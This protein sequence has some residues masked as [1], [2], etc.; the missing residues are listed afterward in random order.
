[1][2]VE[3][4]LAMLM[5]VTAALYAS[6]GHGGA[7]GYLAVMA[8]LG[9]APDEMRVTALVLNLFVS[10]IAFIQFWRTGAF[11]LRLFLAFAVSAVPMAY[12]GGQISLPPAIYKPI[13]GAVLLLS[14][15]LLVWRVKALDSA[16]TKSPPLGIS[17]PAG[18]ALG[19]LAGITGTG[20]GI[21]LS[22]LILLAR[23][24]NATRT[25]GVAAAFIFVN[26]ASGLL[27]NMGGVS[28]LPV[29]LPWLIG[30]VIAGG[31]LGSWLSATRLPR[32]A[33]LRL[34]AVVL[35]IAGGK[36]LLG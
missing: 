28:A 17:V 29:Y 33:I 18:A 21:F 13:V 30:A 9:I 2:P 25:A 8:L 15:V 34:L 19:L 23:W 31:F 12:L 35:V 14:A 6:V 5:F 27:G 22:P 4:I 1:M 26:S 20:G 24:D 3:Y 16:Q 7:S 11:N 10:A 36:L 32:A